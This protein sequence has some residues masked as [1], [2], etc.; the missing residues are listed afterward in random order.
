MV[1]ISD[2]F[3]YWIIY[4]RVINKKNRLVIIF[5]TIF[6]MIWTCT[7]VIIPI[8]NSSF[9][10]FYL[11]ENLSYFKE[12]W[13]LFALLGIVF[14][15]LGINIAKRKRKINNNITSNKKNSK[16]ITSG[17]YRIIRHP[18]YSAWVIIY[19]GLALISDSL[20]SLILCPIL[21]II[22]EIHTSIEENLVLIPKFGN[23][24]RNFKEKTPYR[25]IPTPL[26]FFLI[27]IVIII[28]YIGILNIS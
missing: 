15:I 22:L 20:I 1:F 23:T 11:P 14:I 13:N 4:L 5:Y 8:I 25:I 6:P 16:L 7:L 19:F 18:S 9:L 28:I 24:Y 21:L 27:I 2:L 12:Y 10:R 17:I 26:N 3:V